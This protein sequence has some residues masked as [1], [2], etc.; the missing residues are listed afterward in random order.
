MTPLP[1]HQ[2]TPQHETSTPAEDHPDTTKGKITEPI[3]PMH[4]DP[5][6]IDCGAGAPRREINGTGPGVP[7]RAVAS[8]RVAGL[9]SGHGGARARIGAVWC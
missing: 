2:M 7:A 4:H 3:T 5:M 8:S 9:P 1:D 6:V